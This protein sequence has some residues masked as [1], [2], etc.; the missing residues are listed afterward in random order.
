MPAFG[1]ARAYRGSIGPALSGSHTSRAPAFGVVVS[2]CATICLVAGRVEL[3]V[4][5]RD[6]PLPSTENDMGELVRLA[7]GVFLPPERRYGTGVLRAEM[8]VHMRASGVLPDKECQNGTYVVGRTGT[9]LLS[10]CHGHSSD[11]KYGQLV[12]VAIY[13]KLVTAMHMV[14]P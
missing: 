10:A 14:V 6:P 7:V 3:L 11:S 4:I 13:S 1:A 5:S 12:P 2:A 9:V 8:C